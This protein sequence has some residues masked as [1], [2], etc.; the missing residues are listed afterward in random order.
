[1]VAVLK[2]P[3]YGVPASGLELP[4]RVD[5]L[6]RSGYRVV[7]TDRNLDPPWNLLHPIEARTTP[8][9]QAVLT[10]RVRRRSVCVLAMFESEGHGLALARRLTRRRTPPLVVVG[11]WLSDLVE[12]GGARAALYRWLYRSVDAVVVFSSNQRSTLVSGL[13]LAEDAVHVVPFGV[14]LE[15]IEGRPTSD[16]HTVVAVGRDLG[17]DWA[18]LLEAVTG[19]GW[20]VHLV[21]RPSQVAGLDLPDEV[22]LHATL[23]RSDYLDMLASSSVVVVPTHVREYPT[24]QTVMLE[25]M[26]LGKPCVVTATPAMADYVEDGIDGVLVPPADPLALRDAVDRLLADPN[27]RRRIGAA[28]ARRAAAEGGAASMWRHI[29]AIVDD[30]LAQA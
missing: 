5:L 12:Q 11:C 19:T 3:R 22:T 6:A 17:R 1:M 23:S 29:G 28:A 24:G 16:F 21:T 20:S 26:A 9:V 10:W 30:L 7:W 4:Y 18:T 15:D 14:D 25:A 8:W 2:S 27:A 13:G